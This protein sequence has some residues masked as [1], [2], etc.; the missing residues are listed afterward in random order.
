[1]AFNGYYDASVYP[2]LTENVKKQPET[3]EASKILKPAA[4]SQQS[5]PISL[6]I[7]VDLDFLKIKLS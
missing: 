5:N 6:F 3:K 1:M 4:G 7:L 2:N